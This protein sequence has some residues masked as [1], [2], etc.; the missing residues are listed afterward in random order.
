[1]KE[2]VINVTQ[3]E[4]LQMISNIKEL[5][6]IFEKAKSTIVNGEPVLLVR[7]QAN[8]VTQKFDELTTLDT[9]SEYK[10]SVYKYL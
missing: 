7:R 3:I 5:D 6:Q 4:E 9:L 1:M 10:N 8:G 2:Y